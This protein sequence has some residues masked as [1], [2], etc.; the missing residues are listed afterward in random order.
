FP[1][2]YYLTTGVARNFDTDV[3]DLEFERVVRSPNDEDVLYVFHSRADG[4]SL[5]LPYNTIRKEVANTIVCHGYSLFDDGTMTVFRD[6]P[7][8]PS[9]LHPTQVSR[10]AF[11]PDVYAEAQ[12]V[13]TGP[14]ELIG[15]AEL[16][17]GVSEFLS[18]T[19]MY[20]DME[21]SAEVFD[22]LITSGRPVMER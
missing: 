19:R 16:V 10:T 12:P 22:V 3:T 2:G 11:V 4:R 21:P 17:Q 5:L 14:L 1:G 18:V 8:E 6:T 20:Q 15:N 13:G 7:G 9:A